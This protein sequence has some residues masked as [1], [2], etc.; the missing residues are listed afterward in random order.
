MEAEEEEELE[1]NEEDNLIVNESRGP[2]TVN[3]K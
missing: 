2:Q 3:I 1:E